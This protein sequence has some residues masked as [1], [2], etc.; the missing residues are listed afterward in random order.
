LKGKKMKKLYLVLL[1]FGFLSGCGKSNVTEQCIMNGLGAGH[2][3]FT[4]TGTVKGSV[5]GNI[6]VTKKLFGTAIESEIF[7]SGNVDVNSTVK[8]DFSIPAVDDFCDPGH[9]AYKNDISW[10]DICYFEFK[11]NDTK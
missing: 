4:N 9:D 6:K 8:V 11:H 1:V 5:C 10:T 7:C 3:S 2:C